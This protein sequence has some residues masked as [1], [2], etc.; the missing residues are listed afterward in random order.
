MCVCDLAMYFYENAF[1]LYNMFT[2]V[3]RGRLLQLPY[4]LRLVRCSFL[5]NTCLSLLEMGLE[6][7]SI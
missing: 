1:M 3:C 5:V 4:T 2:Q 6:L 7:Y